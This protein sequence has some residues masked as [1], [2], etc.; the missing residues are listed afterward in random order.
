[1]LIVLILPA[2]KWLLPFAGDVLTEAV[3]TQSRIADFAVVLCNSTTRRQT[4]TLRVT[5]NTYV[6]THCLLRYDTIRNAILMCTQKPTRVSLIYRREQQLKVEN[7]KKLKSKQR[8]FSEVSVYSPGNP[9]S[10]S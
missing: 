6:I 8:M 10:Q 2:H 9:C 4:D 7:R 3:T 5:L 1:M